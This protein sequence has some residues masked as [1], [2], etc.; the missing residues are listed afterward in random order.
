MIDRFDGVERSLAVVNRTEPDPV[1]NMLVETFNGGQVDVSD[2]RPTAEAGTD[3]GTDK[4]DSEEVLSALI[5]DGGTTT[6][7]AVDTLTVRDSAGLSEADLTAV[8]NLVVLIE[9]DE[10]IAASP[11]SELVEAILLVNSDLY[12]T[13]ARQLD[14]IE[15]PPV[16]TGLDGT[17][18]TESQGESLAVHGGDESDK[19][20]RKPPVDSTAGY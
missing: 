19:N 17:L 2:V 6:D 3:D 13:G 18:F 1:R 9:G 14:A 20:I 7:V 16:V 15:L 8:E 12:I 11:L 10:I 4:D 5:G